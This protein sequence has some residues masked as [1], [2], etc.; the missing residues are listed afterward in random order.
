M[1]E[2]RDLETALVVVLD[3]PDVAE[4]HRDAHP[5]AVA[6]RIPLH[7]TILYPFVPRAQLG[8]AELERAR[9]VARAHKAFDFTL[10]R[11]ESWP[12]VVW[13]APEPGEPFRALTAAVHA[14]FPDRPPYGGAF[15]DVVPHATLA[16]PDDVSAAVAELEPRIVPLL[17]VRQHAAAVTLLEET[18]RI[19]GAR[20]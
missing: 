5:R 15:D 12:S 2:A 20:G 3:A 1:T 19:A 7:V 18:R 16:Q 11:L 4:I 17:P 10:A 9:A 14:A 6:R 13:L 8:A